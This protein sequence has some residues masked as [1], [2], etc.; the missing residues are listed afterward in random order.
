[1]EGLTLSQSEK[2]SPAWT[3]HSR[4]AI[5]R[6]DSKLASLSLPRMEF[7]KKG[8][9]SPYRRT[10]I[11]PRSRTRCQDHGAGGARWC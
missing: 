8:K 1:M 4:S 3:L 2:G 11:R 6:E 9:P 5:L 7:Y 10:G